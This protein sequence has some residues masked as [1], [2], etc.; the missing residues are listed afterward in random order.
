MQKLSL[1]LQ[2]IEAT[3]ILRRAFVY[4][5]VALHS[6]H[7]GSMFCGVSECLQ[8]GVPEASAYGDVT[9]ERS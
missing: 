1:I 9:R 7:S 3:T 2:T 8:L 4:A 5:K 6:S